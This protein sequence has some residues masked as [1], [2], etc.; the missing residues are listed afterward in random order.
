MRPPEEYPVKLSMPLV[1]GD[2]DPHFHMNN[3]VYFRFFEAVRVLYFEA[4]GLLRMQ[5][6]TGVGSILKETSCSFKKP[7]RYPDTVSVGARCVGLSTSSLS[8]EYLLEGEKAGVAATGTSVTVV[9]DYKAGTKAPLPEEIRRAVE[10]LE[11]KIF[12]RP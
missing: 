11:E 1:W 10:K 4:I 7:V 5:S 2:L 9:Y 3:V 6:E 8:L 12:D